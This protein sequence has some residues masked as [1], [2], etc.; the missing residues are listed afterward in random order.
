MTE[1]A[2][3]CVK[4]F[5]DKYDSLKEKTSEQFATVT[6]KVDLSVPIII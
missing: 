5:L 1:V 2:V 4:T 6:R 3:D